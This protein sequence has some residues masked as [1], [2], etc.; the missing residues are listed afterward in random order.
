MA[1]A[2][3]SVKGLRQRVSRQTHQCR[4][5]QRTAK[6]DLPVSEIRRYLEPGPVVLVSSAHDNERNIMTM[7]WHTVMEF[8][9]SMVGCVIASGNYS[10]NLILRSRE[11]VINL[12]TTA[13]TDIVVG[14]G[15]TT[16]AEIDKF[17]RFKLTAEKAR[18]VKAP[19]IGE[20]HANLEC[21]LADDRLVDKYNF[22]IFEVLKA[23]VAKSPKHPRTL[24]YTG[25]GVFM[26]SGKVISRRSLF[27]PAML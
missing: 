27:R 10:Y 9:P 4:M 7:G 18:R 14:I 3:R 13:L 20:C 22:F 17:E 15:N 5:T 8:T 23:H 12:P 2:I 16:G 26:V 11:C 25:D 19:L 24:H 1:Q 6:V 21:R